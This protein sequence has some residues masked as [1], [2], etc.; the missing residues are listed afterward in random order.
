MS[1]IK[2]TN[3]VENVNRIYL[4]KLGLSTKRDDEETI[5]Q[6]GSGSKFAPIA[7]LRNGWKWINVGKDDNGIY[8]MEYSSQEESGINCIYYKYTIDNEVSFKPSS[9]TLEAGVL[10]WDNDFQIFREAFSNALDENIARGIEYDISLTDKVEYEEGKFSVYITADPALV[11]ILDNFDSWFDINRTSAYQN[12]RGIV[13]H[14]SKNGMRVYHK[15]VYVYGSNDDDYF[16]IFDYRLN[17]LT[18]NEERR[19][20]DSHYVTSQIAY[21]LEKMFAATSK[22]K[23]FKEAYD[24]CTYF[25]GFIQKD[26]VWETNMLSEYYFNGT[27]AYQSENEHALQLAWKDTFGEKV[28]I[29]T[30][31]Q[32]RFANTISSCYGYQ[33]MVIKNSL[34]FKILSNAGMTTLECILGDELEFDFIHLSSGPKKQLLDEA[35]E[36][37]SKYDDRLSSINE[38]KIFTPN[39]KQES[40]MGVAR[41]DSIYLSATI[42]ED[43]Y[44]T[45]G[46]LIHELDHVVSG[47]GDDD[48][49]FRSLADD[50]IAKLVCQQY[51]GS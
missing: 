8:Q 4:E 13:Y 18:L 31:E 47:I 46:T 11:A 36:I 25:L 27:D 33:T 43:I 28:C 21:L 7:A 37:V 44:K 20:R 23:N 24:C 16:S 32:E 49:G 39:S 40:L 30:Q 22:D 42:L 14:S 6:F 38:V 50:R 17:Y 41:G 3:S 35:L 51:G 34:V 19:V 2:I 5:G 26:N 1:Y 10:S 12:D 48:R 29:L 9:F 45:V 15:G